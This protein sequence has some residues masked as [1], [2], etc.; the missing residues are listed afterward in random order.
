[1]QHLLLIRRNV[2]YTNAPHCY[3]IRTLPVLFNFKQSMIDQVQ[4]LI[5]DDSLKFRC[6][7]DSSIRYYI[8]LLTYLLIYL[9]TYLLI[10][11]LTY[12]LTYSM[13]QS[14]S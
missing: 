1:M 14:P 13:V 12:L 3:F 7:P 2:L 8:G 11:L 5:P 6:F 9:L 10:Y 4:N